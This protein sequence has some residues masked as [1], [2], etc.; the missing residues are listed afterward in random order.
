VSD[1]LFDQAIDR[2]EPEAMV[3]AWLDSLYGGEEFES[4][5]G[6]LADDEFLE[7]VGDLA[8]IRRILGALDGM[9]VRARLSE[10][11]GLDMES[12]GVESV[13]GR[14]RATVCVRL[15]SENEWRVY[16]VNT[17]GDD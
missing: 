6:L 13:C 14:W 3:L 10:A 5:A 15:D 9:Q 11:V 12:V 17:K 7:D 4:L 1:D 8:G 16:A 2:N